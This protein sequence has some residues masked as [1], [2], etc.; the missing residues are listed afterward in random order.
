MCLFFRDLLSSARLPA[1][2][3]FGTRHQASSGPPITPFFLCG[4]FGELQPQAERPRPV[5]HGPLSGV[6]FDDF[7]VAFRICSPRLCRLECTSWTTD[8]RVPWLRPAQMP[9]RRVQAFLQQRFSTTRIKRTLARLKPRSRR[10][11]LAWVRWRLA[12]PTGSNAPIFHT[13]PVLGDH[14]TIPQAE[15][16]SIPQQK[17][18]CRRRHGDSSAALRVSRRCLLRPEAYTSLSSKSRAR[19]I[20]R[21]RTG[22]MQL[23]LRHAAVDEMGSGAY[24]NPA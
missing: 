10:R 7:A 1:E 3:A 18:L 2:E 15:D 13:H 9:R 8:V 23:C 6:F 11:S 24:G 22:A 21:R 5:V 20:A 4:K 19:C 12:T 14:F 17:G 16:V